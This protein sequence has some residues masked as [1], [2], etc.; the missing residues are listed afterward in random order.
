MGSVDLHVSTTSHLS[1]HQEARADFWGGWLRRQPNIPVPVQ[2]TAYMDKSFTFVRGLLSPVLLA[3]TLD[4]VSH[5]L[6]MVGLGLESQL[7]SRDKAA[8]RLDIDVSAGWASPSS[9][10]LWGGDALLLSPRVSTATLSL[11]IWSWMQTMKSPPVSYFV[12]KAAGL[13]SGSQLPGTVLAGEVSLKH[14][15]EIARIKQTDPHG[16][17]IS[18]EGHCKSIMGKGHAPWVPRALQW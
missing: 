5:H 16:D 8:A 7:E 18:L 13:T 2:I 15:F 4:R 12:K 10:G 9:R 3:C 1:Q 6:S 14:V 11:T 17:R